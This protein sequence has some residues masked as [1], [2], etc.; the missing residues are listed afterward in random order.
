MVALAVMA[1]LHPG[2]FPGDLGLSVAWERVIRPSQTL[3]TVVELFGNATWP[4]QAIAIAVGISVVFA[5]LRRWLDIVT[6]LVTAGVASLSNYTIMQIVQRPRP[7]GSGLH[8][9]AHVG[10]P[11]FPS[12]HVEH[13]I[14]YFGFILF[15]TF[16]VQR[17]QRWLW[18]VHVALILLIVMIGPSRLVTGE[19]WPSDI[20]AGYISGAFWLLLAIQIYHWAAG[21]W[22]QL[23]P[24]NERREQ[25]QE[26]A[27]QRETT[28]AV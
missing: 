28:R 14:A 1:K 22:P 23:V 27:E 6:S 24:R 12:G 25:S 17:P 16:M 2:P 10:F 19:H 5:L 7:V 26:H 21:R 8:V 18:I 4:A 9:N 20:L 11:S 15:L 3:T 13:A